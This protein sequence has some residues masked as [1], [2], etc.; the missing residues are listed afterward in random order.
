MP[1]YFSDLKGD[2]NCHQREGYFTFYGGF[3]QGFQRIFQ[4]ILLMYIATG[5]RGFDT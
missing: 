2:Q 4:D 1:G 5:S 3:W